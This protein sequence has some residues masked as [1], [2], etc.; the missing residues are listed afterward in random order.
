MQGKGVNQRAIA[1]KCERPSNV[2]NATE[3]YAA[4]GALVR[5]KNNTK[6]KGMRG[7]ERK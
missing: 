2:A 1:K 7:R 6:T 3:H 5:H 4:A